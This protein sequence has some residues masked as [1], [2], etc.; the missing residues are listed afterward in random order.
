MKKSLGKITIS[1]VDNNMEADYVSIS[2]SD[3][4]SGKLVTKGEMSL[5]DFTKAITGQGAIDIKLEVYDSYETV[6]KKIEIKKVAIPYTVGRTESFSFVPE[7]S[8]KAREHEVDGWE[9]QPEDFNHHR[10]NN[11]MYQC[12]FRRYVEVQ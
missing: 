1:K 10:A 3:R 5:E 6:G 11:G 4:A 12:T 9:L 8:K 2:I 7:M